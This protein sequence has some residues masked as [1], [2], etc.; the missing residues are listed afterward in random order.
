MRTQILDSAR[1]LLT[2]T[3]DPRLPPVTLDEI[4]AQAGIT[5]R[6]LRAYYTS[7][8]AIEADLHSEERS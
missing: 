3:S 8:A 6:Q 2:A 5:T 4:A 7:V 1:E